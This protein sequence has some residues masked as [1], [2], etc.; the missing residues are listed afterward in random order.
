VATAGFRDLPSV[1]EVLQQAP[2]AALLAD[3]PRPLVVAGVRESLASVRAALANGTSGMERRLARLPEE[4]RERVRGYARLSLREVINATGVV[5]HTNLG[6]APLAASAIEAIRA[7]ASGYSNLEYDLEAGARGRRDVHA[8][9]LLERLIGAPAI[10]VNNNAAAIYL[11]LNELAAGGEVIVSR[12]ELIEIGEGF[13]IPDILARSG[14]R[15]REVGTTNRTSAEDYRA[16]IG[17]DTRA[18]LRVHR[19]NFRIVGFTARPSLE[20][21]VEV[22][23]RT[24]LP[25]IED[26]GS[27]CL[28]DLAAYG[29]E[30]EPRMD[31]SIAAGV[32]VITASGDKLLG[33][34]QAG[35]IA[36]KK[37]SI[38]RIRR[39][40]LFRALRVDKLTNAA[41]SATLREYLVGN[42]A[43]I[44]VLAMLAATETQ[45]RDRAARLLEQLPGLGAELVAGRSVIGGGSTPAMDLPTTLIALE[46]PAGTLVTALEQ[47]LRAGDRPVIARVEKDRVLL[48][49]RTVLP[50]QEA[51]LAEAV[52]Q[53]F[54]PGAGA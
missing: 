6:R 52:G 16:A 3:Y 48:D 45:I 10:V 2:V 17:P 5:L 42:H 26:L 8:S 39:H 30:R 49:L 32:D 13:R 41:L 38:A 11:V 14:A 37:D 7:T 54:L 33:G 18:L 21:L 9:S 46:P 50:S 28:V 31:E 4:V 20:E 12:G 27:G 53:A 1:D 40:P 51:A 36:G 44:P 47:R 25:V 19:S 23:R 35:I 22:G 43:G 29:L 34:P 24:G 15:L